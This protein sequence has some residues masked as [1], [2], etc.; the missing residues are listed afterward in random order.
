MRH[1]LGTGHQAQFQ[2]Q[3]STSKH[4]YSHGGSLRNQRAGRGLRPLSCREP[5]HVV[6]K[7][8]KII[9]KHKTL[10]S[11]HGFPLVQRII[12]RYAKRFFVKIEQLSVQNDH[13][14]LLIRTSRR[15][16]FHHFFRVV[17]GQ[18]AQQFANQ[19]LCVTDTPKSGMQSRRL[20]RHRPFS[21][22]VRGYR[23]YRIVRDY[24]QLNQKEV[25]G[26]I[27]YSKLRLGG[28]SM[29]D[30]KLLWA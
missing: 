17:A 10:R 6:F 18:I 19:G 9:L 2:F 20:W 8:N 4:R 27:R 15:S 28:L 5:L 3:S 11:K 14:H 7:V 24:I 29:G 23:A 25:L 22:V 12:K 26:V 21:R 13:L 1:F 30:W 16:L